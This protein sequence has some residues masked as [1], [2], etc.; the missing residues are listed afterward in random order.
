M[1]LFLKPYFEQKPWAGE[2]LNKIYE[3][4]SGTGEAWIV[5]G[6]NKKSS[7]ILNGIY[8]GKSLRWVYLNHPE[9]FGENEE[10]EFPLLLKLISAGDDLSVQVHPNDDYA[11]KTKN[12]LGKFEFLR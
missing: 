12:Q 10:K 1:I 8:K 3:C 6:Y 9:L 5:S 11:L 2:E 7:T 4:P